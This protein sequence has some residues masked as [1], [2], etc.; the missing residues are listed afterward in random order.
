MEKVAITTL[1]PTSQ[2]L[3][4]CDKKQIRGIFPPLYNQFNFWI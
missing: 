3:N 2:Y 4:M 1:P